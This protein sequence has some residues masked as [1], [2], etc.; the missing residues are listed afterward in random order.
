[1][2]YFHWFSF[3]YQEHLRIRGDV[4]N[5]VRSSGRTQRVKVDGFFLKLVKVSSGITQCSVLGPSPVV[6]FIN[7]LPDQL[8]YSICKMFADD[9]KIYRRLNQEKVNKL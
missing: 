5:W 7:D 8:K 3:W 9:C 2:E 4:L 1:M 6:V